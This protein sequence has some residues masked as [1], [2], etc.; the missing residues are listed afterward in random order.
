M[1]THSP[2]KQ[3]Q[4]WLRMVARL[5]VIDPSHKV[6]YRCM[7]TRE[8]T[9]L[10]VIDN[11]DTAMEWAEEADKILVARKGNV[12]GDLQQESQTAF[13]FWLSPIEC[14]EPD[15]DIDRH[16]SHPERYWK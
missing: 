15:V 13:G 6:D 2:R 5:Q 16:P 14:L 11:R 9:R 10:P 1:G 8:A 7:V 4:G 12:S 3:V